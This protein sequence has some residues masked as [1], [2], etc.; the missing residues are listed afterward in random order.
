M[1]GHD[2]V[3]AAR[4][5]KLAETF[6]LSRITEADIAFAASIDDV[7]VAVIGLQNIAGIDDGGIASLCFPDDE[8]WN[9]SDLW[10]APQ[11]EFATYCRMTT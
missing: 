10:V 11:F 4:R 5:G 6:D 3:D 9:W 1:A 8:E 2:E 7:D